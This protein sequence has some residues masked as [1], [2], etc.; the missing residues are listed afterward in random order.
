MLTKIKQT[1]FFSVLSVLLGLPFTAS[2]M[3]FNPSENLDVHLG[4]SATFEYDSF[5]LN[6]GL[7]LNYFAPE[8]SVIEIISQGDLFVGGELRVSPNSKLI[9]NSKRGELTVTGKL[10]T[11]SLHYKVK[12]G[13]E[14]TSKGVFEDY[15]EPLV[16]DNGLAVLRFSP[17]PILEYHKEP[18]YQWWSSSSFTM[19]MQAPTIPVV[20]TPIPAP[21][22][23]FSSGLV[24]LTLI[25]KKLQA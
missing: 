18:A 6:E 2:A 16:L 10:V 4:G 24:L 5:A 15:S 3:V 8:N 1:A 9:L 20:T 17:I 12:V 14:D 25:R 22:F 11:S 19:T 23:L 21:V 7:T 13:K